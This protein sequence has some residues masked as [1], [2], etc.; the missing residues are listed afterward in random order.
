VLCFRGRHGSWGVVLVLV[1]VN[2]AGSCVV[3]VV[4]WYLGKVMVECGGGV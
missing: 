4:A 2:A 1:C 3:V